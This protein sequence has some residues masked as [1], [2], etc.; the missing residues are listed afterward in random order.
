MILITNKR[1]NQHS[2]NKVKTTLWYRYY[3][4]EATITK[5]M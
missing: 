4:Y 1:G 5:I 3:Y 2:P